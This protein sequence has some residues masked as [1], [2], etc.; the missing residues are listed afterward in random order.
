[1]IFFVTGAPCLNGGHV[2]DFASSVGHLRS[3]FVG[4]LVYD[5]MHTYPGHRCCILD[6]SRECQLDGKGLISYVDY[7]CGI[8]L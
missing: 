5:S 1:M 6:L 3:D 8:K 4:L 7:I 2:Y